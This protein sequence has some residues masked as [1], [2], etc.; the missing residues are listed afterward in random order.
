MITIRSFKAEER[1]IN[2][3]HKILDENLIYHYPYRASTR[4]LGFR[5]EIV[6]FEK[7]IFFY[8]ETNEYF[9]DR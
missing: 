3:F 6:I 4:W 2:K 8:P 1:F 5:L 9:I 7:I